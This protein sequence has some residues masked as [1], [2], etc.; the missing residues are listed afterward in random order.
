MIIKENRVDAKNI[1]V[2]FHTWKRERTVVIVANT[3]TGVVWLAWWMWREEEEK[4]VKEARMVIRRT[5]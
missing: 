1:T 5:M 3:M 4:V 2:I